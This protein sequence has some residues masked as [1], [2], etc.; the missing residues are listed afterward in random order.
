[1]TYYSLSLY[2]ILSIFGNETSQF[3]EFV[4]TDVVIVKD[5]DY[6]TITIPF[7]VLPTYHIQSNIGMSN[8]TIATKVTFKDHQSYKVEHQEFSLRHDRIII[9]NGDEH[10]VMA[11]RFEI[12]VTLKLNENN[13]NEKLEGELYYQ[14]CTDRQCLFP[15]TL[16]F[17]ISL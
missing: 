2:F 6:A 3:V 12:K 5:N 15:R 7:E 9:L 13:S 10:Q 1:M 4:E 16:N 14:T 17:K 8:G 11:N